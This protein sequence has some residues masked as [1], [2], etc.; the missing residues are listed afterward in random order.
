MEGGSLVVDGVKN[1]AQLPDW[2]YDR[3]FPVWSFEIWNSEFPD[4]SF[5]YSLV[6]TSGDHFNL[7]PLNKILRTGSDEHY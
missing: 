5:N 3:D 1:A 6:G 2:N 7:F 4:L